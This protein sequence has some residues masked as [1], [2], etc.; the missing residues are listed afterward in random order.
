MRS[1]FRFLSVVLALA[2]IMSAIGCSS[3]SSNNTTETANNSAAVRMMKMLPEDFGGFY[4]SDT[5]EMRNNENL[6]PLL[7]FAIE[8]GGMRFPEWED[9]LGTAEIGDENL[10][11][12]EGNFSLEQIRVNTSTGLS[13]NYGSFSI[14]KDS[15]NR[16]V[17]MIGNISI[18]GRDEDIRR[19][20]DV[21]NGKTVSIYDSVKDVVDRLPDAFSLQVAA[22]SN[23][24][25]RDEYG[26]LE[27]GGSSVNQGDSNKQTEI[28]KFNS[29]ESA[30]RYAEDMPVLFHDYF[31][32]DVT[33]D[34]VFVTVITTETM[35]PLAA[36]EY[37]YLA[38]QESNQS[39]SLAYLNQAI[40]L[41]PSNAEAFCARGIIQQRLGNNAEAIADLEKCLTLNP[42]PYIQQEAETHLQQLGVTQ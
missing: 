41:D 12:I 16:S 14:W 22:F 39:K 37:V 3:V 8:E 7:Y 4:Y 9:G 34:G 19:C 27:W 10:Y 18:I 11:L 29:S 40:T 23:G 25:Y 36:D 17:V 33:R 26:L 1:I 35:P 13:D 31:N 30:Q 32:P 38:Q 6:L 28:Y 42:Y 24:W 15:S 2:S 21:L 5:Y 20:I